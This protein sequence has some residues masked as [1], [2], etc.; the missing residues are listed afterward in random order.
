[1]LLCACG[2]STGLSPRVR[3]NRVTSLA[4]WAISRSI[5][6]CAGEPDGAEGIAI[7]GKV[8][9][10]VCGGTSPGRNPRATSRGLSPRVRG[11]HHHGEPV[12]VAD[13]SIPA[14]AGEPPAGATRAS[15]LSVYPRV[16]G[17]TPCV[18]IS[19]IA[20]RHWARQLGGYWY[21]TKYMPS[22]STISFGDSPK[23]RI[24]CSPTAAGSRQV[25][26]MEPLP[27]S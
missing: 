5:P 2:I 18:A 17:G 25:I 14:C 3:G 7:D 4:N 10:R 13:R 23:V 15:L 20:T 27:N 26:T 9:P 6:A 11:N 1:M 21:F 8:Y 19:Y 16:C 22:A 24:L 12:A